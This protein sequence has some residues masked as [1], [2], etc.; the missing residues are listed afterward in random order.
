MNDDTSGERSGAAPTLSRGAVTHPD[1]MFWDN[2]FAVYQGQ[3]HRFTLQAP[4][5]FPPGHVRVF[6]DDHPAAPATLEGAP[7]T[8]DDRHHLA[9]IGYLTS[10]DAVHWEYR[11]AAIRPSEEPAAWDS[12]VIWSGNAHVVAGRLVVPYTGR[13]QQPA[14]GDRF[15][16]QIGL[17]ILDPDTGHFDKLAQ[18]PVL[19]PLERSP[20][21]ARRAEELG[22]DIAGDEL[23]IMAWRDPYFLVDEA[24]GMVHMFFA[25]KLQAQLVAERLPGAPGRGGIG[26][27][28]ARIDALDRW[29]LL[30]PL[31][32]PA[33]YSQLELPIVIQR[34]GEYVLL[35]SVA[36]LGADGSRRQSLRG[37]RAGALHGPWQPIHGD[38]D[39]LVPLEGIYGI[40]MAPGLDGE[41]HAVCF[42]EQALAISPLRRVT[43]TGNV[44]HIPPASGW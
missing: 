40:N 18:N 22:Y 17:A 10:A 3:Y 15:L 30:E 12:H 39:L 32:L 24:A 23:V 36:E 13:S 44:P 5:R 33:A 26:H 2:W 34:D 6:A 43:W 28:V 35:S 9:E 8:P 1:Y 42:Y 31:A 29:E 19:S 38:S 14:N 16:Q 21:G 37:Y 7:T 41:Y 20:G 4:R 27:A 11:G 25:A